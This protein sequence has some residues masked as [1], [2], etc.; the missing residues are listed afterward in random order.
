MTVDPGPSIIR[1]LIAELSDHLD[2][3][4]IR[5]NQ[6]GPRP[7]YVFGQYGVTV[8]NESEARLRYPKENSDPTKVSYLYV[9]PGDAVISLSFHNTSQ[10][11]NPL[12]EPDALAKKAR[13]WFTIFGIEFLQELG[14]V[15]NDLS[16]MQ[17]RTILI[18]GVYEYQTGFD[19]RIKGAREVELTVDA[20]DLSDT[21]I[22][23][24][25][26]QS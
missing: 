6:D 10:K 4:I 18:D 13:D 9:I 14:V 21:E 22:T 5:K 3:D 19:F 11:A 25:E 12:D 23:Y 2:V 15:C 1:E 8:Q 16:S 7:E 26:M 20:M 24:E 17:D